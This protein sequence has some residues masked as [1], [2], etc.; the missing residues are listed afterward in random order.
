MISNRHRDTVLRLPIGQLANW[1]LAAVRGACRQDR[2]V[3]IRSL[4]EHYGPNVTLLRLVPRLR[5]G[6][7]QCRQ[8]PTRLSL[9]N[10]FPV[11]PGPSLVEGVLVDVR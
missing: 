4:P 1:H 7:P 11:Q 5:C 6:F 8:P 9:R 3:S 10:R 2:V